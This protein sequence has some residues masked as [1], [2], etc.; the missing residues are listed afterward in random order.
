MPGRLTSARY[1][2]PK[3]TY[4]SVSA[5]TAGLQAIG[6]RTTPKPSLVPTTKV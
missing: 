6:S 2:D 3:A 4:W 5:M 1:S